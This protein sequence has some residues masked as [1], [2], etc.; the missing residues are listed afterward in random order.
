MSAAHDD[1]TDSLSDWIEKNVPEFLKEITA[2]NGIEI[3]EQW[4]MPLVE[5]FVL[6]IAVKDMT[7]NGAGV[8]A[9]TRK[10]T[11]SYRIEGLL[12]SALEM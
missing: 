4:Q 1:I 11:S 6:V 5:D 10:N 2:Q 7:D 3:E 8:F 12:A 9:L